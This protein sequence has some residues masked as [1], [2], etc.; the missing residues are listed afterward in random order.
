MLAVMDTQ[1]ILSEIKGLIGNLD[2]PARKNDVINHARQ[3]GARQETV[4]ALQEHLPS[5]KYDGVEDIM[6]KLPFGN[7]SEEIDKFL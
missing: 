7:M 6:S 4:Q 2:F 5:Q 3:Q 1:T